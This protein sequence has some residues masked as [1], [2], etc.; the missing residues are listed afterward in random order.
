MIAKTKALII[1]YNSLAASTTDLAAVT[2]NF[3]EAETNEI[4]CLN[5]VSDAELA[6]W[7]IHVDKQ[8]LNIQW[9]NQNQ[10]PPSQR[11]RLLFC[12]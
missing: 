10:L 9:T 7:V 4:D 6:K 12:P 8:Y 1:S 11:R 2:V 5:T 3:S